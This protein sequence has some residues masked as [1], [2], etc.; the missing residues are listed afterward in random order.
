MAATVLKY[1]PTRN[2]GDALAP[3]L[4]ERLSGVAPEVV[5]LREPCERANLLTVGSVLRMADA[6]TTVWGSGF[7]SAD[8]GLGLQDWGEARG[9]VRARPAAVRAVRGPLT[10]EKLRA[11]S[12]DCP[13]VYGD[14]AL[15]L[16]RLVQP[17]AKR[18]FAL[19]VVPH[20]TD[21]RHPALEE[22]RADPAVRVIDVRLGK[23][24]LLLGRPDLERF[25]REITRCERIVSSSLHGLVVA[26]AYG[27]PSQRARL[28]DGVVGGDFK[29]EDFLASVGR[30]G[31]AALTL[32]RTTTRQAILDRFRG[33]T[34]TFDPE[35]LLAAAPF[36]IVV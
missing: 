11:M 5:P 23:L 25:I 36:E 21:R 30:E 3:W 35:P 28:G 12:V 2:W 7:I 17:S 32:D 24:G 18:S 8:D 31:E 34:G 10:R 27:I 6:R 1:D 22:L 33:G 29:F 19:G 16:P 14:P 26:E 13:E 9:E 20:Y 15:L 4:I